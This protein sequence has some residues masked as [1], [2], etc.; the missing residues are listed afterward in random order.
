MS[1]EIAAE[2]TASIRFVSQG[3]QATSSKRLSLASTRGRACGWP[4]DV[5]TGKTAL[6]MLVSKTAIEAGRTVAIYS[7]PKLL[8]RIRAHL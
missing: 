2:M 7:L 5:G 4:A 1:L 8:A 3:R 6:A